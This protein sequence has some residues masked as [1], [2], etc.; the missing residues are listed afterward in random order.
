MQVYVPFVGNLVLESIFQGILLLQTVLARWLS[1]AMWL[2]GYFTGAPLYSVIN[3]SNL[4]NCFPIAA[5]MSSPCHIEI[6]L[7]EKEDAVAKPDEE[8][9]VKKKESKKKLKRQMR[10]QQS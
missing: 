8:E 3:H 6:I 1:K 7:G 4:M 9:P 2:N 10:T 5:Y